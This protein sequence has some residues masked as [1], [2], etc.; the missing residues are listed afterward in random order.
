M[1]P[2]EARELKE[3]ERELQR[4]KDKAAQL[5]KARAD[6][7]E[8]NAT[9][10]KDGTGNT[11]GGVI[12]VSPARKKLETVNG[13]F[14][15]DS[16]TINTF[17]PHNWVAHLGQKIFSGD[18]RFTGKFHTGTRNSRY[19]KNRKA[20]WNEFGSCRTSQRFYIVADKA[21]GSPNGLVP[22]A[23]PPHS[24]GFKNSDR[25]VKIGDTN[26]FHRSSS[27]DKKLLISAKAWADKKPGAPYWVA[28]KRAS[29]KELTSSLTYIGNKKVKVFCRCSAT[30]PLVPSGPAIDY[31]LTVII[32][33]DK[34]EYSIS[35]SHDGFPAYEIYINGIRV[36]EHDPFVT[37]ETPMS[38][39]GKKG[40]HECRI[41]PK[42]LP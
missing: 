22:D 31:S 32:D 1:T 33:R 38:L 42:N 19:W 18:N 6:W 39:L 23:Y 27:L 17:I 21:S 37:G 13:G 5:R 11:I 3:F 30:N 28:L 9:G 2:E 4:T 40:E 36:Y 20:T 29:Q 15:V 24:D 8:K 25:L 12:Y 14:P 26:E 7:A 10:P 41:G 35:G 16:L 34:N